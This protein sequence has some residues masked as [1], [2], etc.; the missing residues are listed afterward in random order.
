MIRGV[1][2]SLKSEIERLYFLSDELLFPLDENVCCWAVMERKRHGQAI[3]N[4]NNATKKKLRKI[5]FLTHT[6]TKKIRK[7]ETFRSKLFE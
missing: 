3:K 4:S 7:I 2:G 6:N 1:D 5:N